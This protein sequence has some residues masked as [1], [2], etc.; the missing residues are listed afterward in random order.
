MPEKKVGTLKPRK[1]K[2][3]AT[4]SKIE[5]CLIEERTPIGIAMRTLSRNAVPEI[6]SVT[7][8]RP[9]T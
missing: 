5:Y 9:M 8:S 3:V 7:G 4:W 2:V 6:F 1:A